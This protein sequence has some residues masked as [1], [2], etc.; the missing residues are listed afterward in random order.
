MAN[1]QLY[2]D[3]TGQNTKQNNGNATP[4]NRVATTT[5]L[6]KMYSEKQCQ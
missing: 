4:I 1:L 6:T 3:E 2:L 5:E